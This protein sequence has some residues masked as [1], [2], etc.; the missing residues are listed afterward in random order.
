MSQSCS[1][2]RGLFAGHQAYKTISPPLTTPFHVTSL[3]EDQIS[4]GGDCPSQ[5]EGSNSRGEGSELIAFCKASAEKNITS[6]HPQCP[7]LAF[8][9]CEKGSRPCKRTEILA[10]RKKITNEQSRQQ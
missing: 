3:P 4:P 9:V 1:I 2:S 8:P 10:A 7:S 6:S 5:A